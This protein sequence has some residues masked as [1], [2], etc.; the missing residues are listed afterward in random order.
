MA[1]GRT[2]LVSMAAMAYIYGARAH[3]CTGISLERSSHCTVKRY[4]SN[5]YVHTH[6]S[7]YYS[8]N[9]DAKSVTRTKN[10]EKTKN[11]K[12][13]IE[14]LLR[15]PFD[16][17]GRRKNERAPTNARRHDGRWHPLPPWAELERP[18][19]Y[20]ASPA[21]PRPMVSPA[22]V[23]DPF[24]HYPSDAAGARATM[25]NLPAC[26]RDMDI[27]GQRSHR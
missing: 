15:G 12:Q 4:C 8:S 6:P 7:R 9:R 2:H 22:R 21:L 23:R 17:S 27:M 20:H 26:A 1:A 14:T 24:T 11:T 25:V 10:N 3:P 16:Y 18:T 5:N 19:I 13:C